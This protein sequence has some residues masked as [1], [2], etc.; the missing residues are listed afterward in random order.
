MSMHVHA[1]PF[2]YVSWCICSFAPMH[3]V[4]APS[5]S[6][7]LVSGELLNDVPLARSLPS[8]VQVVIVFLCML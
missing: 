4:Q 8:L 5:C 2:P 7:S 3:L 1:C 6:F